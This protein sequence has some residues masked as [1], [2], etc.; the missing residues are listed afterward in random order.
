VESA[1]ADFLLICT[2]T[3]HKVAPQIE[4]AISIPILHIA[5][6]TAGAILEKG[7]HTVGLLGTN[8]TM[9]QEFYRGRLQEEFDLQ[10]LIPSAA[11]RQIVHRI[12]YDELVLGIVREESR[13]EYLRIMH[14]MVDQGAE[15]IIEGCTEIVMLVQQEHIEMPLF[16]TTAIHAS[17]AVDWALQ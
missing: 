3:M 10:V 8:F 14:K 9:E 12:I 7:M 2:N 1:G 16:D 15:G 17:T 4:E 6:A 11:D 5:D 13:A